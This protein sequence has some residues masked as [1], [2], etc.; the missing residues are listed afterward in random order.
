[1]S[2]KPTLRHN[3][4]LKCSNDARTITCIC[5]YTRKQVQITRMET[6]SHCR[7]KQDSFSLAV[8]GSMLKFLIALMHSLITLLWR[9]LKTGKGKSDAKDNVVCRRFVR[10]LVA[11]CELRACL[12]SPTS[13]GVLSL[14]F[15]NTDLG[16]ASHYSNNVR[17]KTHDLSLFL[18]RHSFTLSYQT[19]IVDTY[20]IQSIF[21]RIIWC[22]E[23]SGK[24]RDGS[25]P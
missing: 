25:K 13:V 19:A 4:V 8:K 14:Y 21:R 22:A 12:A 1:M 5:C 10:K 20:L 7:I 15:V 11:L 17:M 16:L 23:R 3:G 6:V 9:Y 18:I 2:H 24:L